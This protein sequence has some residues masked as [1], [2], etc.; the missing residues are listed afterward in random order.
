MAKKHGKKQTPPSKKMI[1]NTEQRNSI[2]I[3]LVGCVSSG[4]STLLNSICVNQYE[5]M[6]RKRTTMLPSVYKG[7][8][9]NIYNNKSEVSRIQGKNKEIYDKIYST[10]TH[11]TLTN[12]TCSL[13]EHIIPMIKGFVDVPKDVFVDIYDSVRLHSC[14]SIFACIFDPPAPHFEPFR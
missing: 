12:E 3:A 13:Q 7:S 10:K 5:D 6:K 8:N 4:K 9:M 2:R 14:C 11:A 1:N